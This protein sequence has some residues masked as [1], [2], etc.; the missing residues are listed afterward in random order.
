[1]KHGLHSFPAILA[2][3]RLILFYISELANI[4]VSIYHLSKQ[5]LS[6]LSALFRSTVTTDLLN[7]QLVMHFERQ[8]VKV[9]IY[10]IDMLLKDTFN[11]IF[12][13]FIM[14]QL[15]CLL[16]CITVFTRKESSVN[17]VIPIG[18][19]L[20]GMYILSNQSQM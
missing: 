14:Y 16:P 5:L 10:T 9:L 17:E 4:F 19:H 18:C 2:I 7:V 8:I 11:D 6:T 12:N 13:C 15:V 3:S 1:M 20:I